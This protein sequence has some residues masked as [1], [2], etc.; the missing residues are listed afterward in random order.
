MS[1]DPSSHDSAPL[2]RGLH[3]A[4]GA[5]VGLLLGWMLSSYLP[6]QLARAS[7]G[8]AIVVGLICGVLGYFHGRAF[9]AALMESL[10]RGLR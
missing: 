9:W 2:P 1:D 3:A 8:F 4:L 10:G 7:L 5:F 6:M